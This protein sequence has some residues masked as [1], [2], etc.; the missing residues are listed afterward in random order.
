[1]ST[2]RALTS[3]GPISLR[4]SERLSRVTG[5]MGGTSLVLDE[6]GRTETG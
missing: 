1:M 3:N 4:V 5:D 6:R 2:V